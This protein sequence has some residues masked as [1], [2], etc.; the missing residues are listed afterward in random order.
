[1]QYAFTGRIAD[2]S[3]R[4]PFHQSKSDLQMELN[5]ELVTDSYI[6]VIEITFALLHCFVASTLQYAAGVFSISTVLTA[7]PPCQYIVIQRFYTRDLV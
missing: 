4:T 6:C 3:R 1:M 7:V 5:I 2:S